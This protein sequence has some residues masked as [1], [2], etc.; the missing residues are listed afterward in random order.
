MTCSP[1]KGVAGDAGA[2]GASCVD[3]GHARRAAH[4]GP[5]GRGRRS[6]SA[7]LGGGC[8]STGSGRCSSSPATRR[9]PHGPYADGMTFLRALLEHD[10]GVVRVGVPAYPDGHP[11]IDDVVRA[12]GAARQAGAA[13][14]R[15]G[16]AGSVT[17]QMCLD[18]ARSVGGW[19]TNGRPGSTLPVDL[20]VP[21]VV[22]RAELMTDGRAARRRSLAALPAPSIGRPWVR[23]MSPGGYDPT[24]LVAGAGR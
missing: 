3:L 16:I 20:G 12:G 22:D 2:D 11:L 24:E 9:Y 17:T 5:H 4:R 23:L 15:P 8:V 19:P 10:T 13:R 6:T 14:R 18:P 7:E 1:A 21:G